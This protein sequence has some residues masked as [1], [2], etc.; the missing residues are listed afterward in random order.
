ME[1]WTKLNAI[2]EMHMDAL[3][4]DDAAPWMPNSCRHATSFGHC[5]GGHQ[6]VHQRFGQR[7]V[8]LRLLQKMPDPSSDQNDPRPFSVRTR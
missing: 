3:D 2:T 6:P 1:T 8:V 4:T 7:R 5:I